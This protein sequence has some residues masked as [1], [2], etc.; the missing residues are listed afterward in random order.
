M[1][2]LKLFLRKGR[3]GLTRFRRKGRT[4]LTLVL[5]A[6]HPAQPDFSRALRKIGKANG[7]P[8]LH[9][10]RLVRGLKSDTLRRQL[11]EARLQQRPLIVE[12]GLLPET[13][14]S[15]FGER[16]VRSVRQVVTRIDADAV[17][18]VVLISPQDQ[19]L[20]ASYVRRAE[21]GVATTFAQ[22]LEQF[23]PMDL[24]YGPLLR[25][26]AAIPEVSKVVPVDW[27]LARKSL[28]NVLAPVLDVALGG[29]PRDAL[30]TFDRPARVRGYASRR[31]VR[32]A[33]A[34][35]EFVDNDKEHALI[36]KMVRETFPARR[37]SD[38]RYLDAER[39]AKIAAR[40]REDRR[41]Y[42]AGRR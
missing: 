1:R 6:P 10:L 16:T 23:E 32:V 39:R 35:H 27:S 14:L 21:N 19:L 15:P 40:Y 37:F 30:D 17:N 22:H 13:K 29:Q 4:G 5:W 34:M 3:T 33:L 24:L 20:E 2:R 31:G 26:L 42:K 41:V 12:A 9:S 11:A 36:R 7:G 25:D 18:I 28:R 38:V 8:V